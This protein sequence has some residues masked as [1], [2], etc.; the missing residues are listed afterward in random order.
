MVFE[1]NPKWW[2]QREGN[3]THATFVPIKSN[4]TRMAVLLSGEVD[5]PTDPPVQDLERLKQ[6]ADVKL[7]QIDEPRDFLGLRRGARRTEVFQR[8]R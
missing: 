1:A 8:Q 6:A 2:G 7:L 4:A 5:V 3:V